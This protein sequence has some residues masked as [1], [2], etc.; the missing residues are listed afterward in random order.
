MA[1]SSSAQERGRSWH[2]AAQ[3]DGKPACRARHQQHTPKGW[4][5]ERRPPGPRCGAAERPLRTRGVRWATLNDGVMDT[6]ILSG[7]ARRGGAAW[8]RLRQ[9]LKS[10]AQS[11]SNPAPA[12]R[13][14]RHRD[15]DDAIT[16]P[17][18]STRARVRDARADRADT[19][20]GTERGGEEGGWRY[21]RNTPAA[22]G[23]A[24]IGPGTL[25]EQ[26]FVS[27]FVPHGNLGHPRRLAAAR[28]PEVSVNKGN[29]SEARTAASSSR[30]ARRA[31]TRR[32]RCAAN[33]SP[34][35]T[36]RPG[37]TASRRRRAPRR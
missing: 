10:S 27:V 17:T 21:V 7:S 3:R 12:G 35:R 6:D 4:Q 18:Q 9:Q 19:D 31:R 15:T 2:A 16:K 8:Y 26:P 24:R 29:P 1:P 36:S 25:V 32:R 37:A 5:E 22:S 14:D 28:C 20:G 33:S 13:A 11:D 34:T 23:Q 30:A